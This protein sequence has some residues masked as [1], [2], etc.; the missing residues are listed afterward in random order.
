MGKV[1]KHTLKETNFSQQKHS[2]AEINSWI[3]EINILATDNL[4]SSRNI[5]KL[6]SR[7]PLFWLVL[8]YDLLEDRRTIDV[9]ITKFVILYYIKQ[10]DFMFLCVCS[11]TDHRGRQTVVRTSVTHSAIASCA[12]CLFLP[13]FDV[14]CDLLLNRRKLTWNLFVEK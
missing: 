1:K 2:P 6:T 7:F 5:N 12:T 4:E 8:A 10:I 14:I 13:Q 11:V 9:T 3:K